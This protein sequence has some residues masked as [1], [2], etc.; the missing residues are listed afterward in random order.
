MT[1][2]IAFFLSVA[3][4]AFVLVFLGAALGIGRL[5][6]YGVTPTLD[7]QLLAQLQAREATY[8]A[9][10]AQANQQLQATQ[11]PA[12]ATPLPTVAQDPTA[13]YPI[14]PDLAAYLALSAAAP[15]S[16]LVSDPALVDFQGTAAYEVT[17]NTGRVY[18]DA[19]S[20]AILFNGAAVSPGGGGAGPGSRGE[21]DDGGD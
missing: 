21:G 16:Y 9:M 11:P 3:L 12:M 1:Q 10:I 8:Q 20:G 7:P 17:F 4:T 18:V 14:S 6:Q 2:R 13:G 19:T 15:G 5:A